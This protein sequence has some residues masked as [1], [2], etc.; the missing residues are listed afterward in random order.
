MCSH[1]R[2][3]F[4]SEKQG[5]FTFYNC[6]GFPIIILLVQ[7]LPY[8]LYFLF[9]KPPSFP[10]YKY[11][12]IQ[13]TP[14]WALGCRGPDMIPVGITLPP[15][16]FGIWSPNCW[17]A[18]YTILQQ[19]NIFFNYMNHNLR[20]QQTIFLLSNHYLLQCI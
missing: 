18:S 20:I 10:I 17:F 13:Q 6:L 1:F 7:I 15:T 19:D 3:H 14:S 9:Y 8:Q 12:I 2:T 4:S 16:K 5:R 11:S